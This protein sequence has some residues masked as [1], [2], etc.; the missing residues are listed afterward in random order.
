MSKKQLFTI[1]AALLFS[2]LI[3]Q[4]QAHYWQQEVDYKI[5]IRLNTENHNFEGE[6]KLVYINHSPDSLDKVFYHLYFNAFQPGSMMDV[7]SLNIV[8]PDRR[9]KD[10]ISKLDED[11]IGRQEVRSL[12][13]NGYPCYFEVHETLLKVQLPQK[14]APGDTAV[15]DMIFAGQV[16]LQIRRSGRDNAEGVDYTMT[17]WYPKMAAYDESGWHPYP[18][19][20]RE[21]YAPFGKFEVSITLPS[22]YKVGGTGSLQNFADYWAV[23]STEA[24]QIRYRLKDSEDE[25]RTWVFQAENVHDF[26]WAADP[27]Y[28]HE[29]TDLDENLKLHF[30][31]LEDYADTWTR[32]PRYTRQFF[33][34]MNARFG[35]YPYPQFSAIQGGDGGMEYPMCTMLKGTGNISGLVGVT[36]H[37]GAHNWFYG[38]LGSNENR[39]PWMDEG[40]TSFAEEEVLNAM[41]R[42]PKVNAHRSAYAAHAFLASKPE[43][44][45]PMITPADY[46]QINRT[47]SINSYSRGQIFLAQLRYIIGKP[48][49]DRGMKKF[50]D[51][52]QFKHPTA[53]DLL[54]I[55]ER[56]SG[57]HLD[58]Y[59][60][61]WVETNKLIDYG[62]AG[63]K[64]RKG[65]IR[66]Q[67]E[68]L[69]T[70]PMPLRVVIETRDGRS[71]RYYIPTVSQMGAPQE[72]GVMVLKAWP[73]THPDYEVE[74]KVN[75]EDIDKIYLDKEGFMADINGENNQ[76]PKE[77]GK[78]N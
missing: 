60:H 22:E 7:R 58:W 12:T 43:Q 53:W 56:E 73:W 46:Y 77:E 35:R 74:L 49:F 59:Y 10:R 71:L 2:G 66:L 4:P 5:D 16:P 37:E 1:L 28:V 63:I 23:E 30:F 13:L 36:V 15:L 11:E 52:W 17:Q 3:A 70:M 21:F 45:E 78:E 20:G 34:E 65:G 69:G 26:A 42:E 64:G 41:A 44:M 75:F 57:L 8:D 31:Y 68:N 14:I 24:E 48:A 50:Y 61:F 9:V 6:Q 18:Y 19:V 40:F 54:R 55:M 72:E 27:E 39:F 33:E 25:L 47:Y 32:L 51:S 38:I 67:L 29:A 76:Y 62:I